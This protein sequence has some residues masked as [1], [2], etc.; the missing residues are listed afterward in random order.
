MPKLERALCV[1]LVLILSLVLTSAL[2][3]QFYMHEQPCPLCLLQ[4]LGMFGVATGVLLNVRFGV[5]PAHYA[6]SLFSAIFGGF[7]AIRQIALHVCPG[8]PEFGVPVFGLSLYTWSFIVFVCA[9]AY[10]AF[11]ML[12]YSSVKS[13]EVPV[14]LSGFEK[15]GFGVIVL[16]ILINLIATLNQC[17]IGP[18]AE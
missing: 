17:G 15:F 3:V 8:F 14:Q 11:T 18:C 16:L 5:Q 13:P 1:G 10:I 7:V 6:L 9:A 12:F 4:R 2:W